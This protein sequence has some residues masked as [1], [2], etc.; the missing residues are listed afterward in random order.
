VSRLGAELLGVLGESRAS[1]RTLAIARYGE[2]GGRRSTRFPAADLD[3]ACKDSVFHTHSGQDGSAGLPVEAGLDHVLVEDI[4]VNA[5][6][7]LLPLVSARHPVNDV[8]IHRNA[9]G[10]RR[11]ALAGSS[12]AV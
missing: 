10:V 5:V 7:H 1:G 2:G 9:G 11:L 4:A 8:D 6:E 12:C 3:G